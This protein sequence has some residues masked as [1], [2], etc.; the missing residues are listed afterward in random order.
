MARYEAERTLFG[1]VA[2]EPNL[3]QTST[4]AV[5]ELEKWFAPIGSIELGKEYE[6]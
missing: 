5:Q 1:V 2:L 4:F 3:T 6:L